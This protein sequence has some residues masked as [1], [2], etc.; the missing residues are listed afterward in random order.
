MSGQDTIIRSQGWEVCRTDNDKCHNDYNTVYWKCYW[1]SVMHEQQNHHSWIKTKL[2]KRK[3]QPPWFLCAQRTAFPIHTYAS[4]MNGVEA[5]PLGEGDGEETLTN[6]LLSNELKSYVCMRACWGLGH[7]FWL[8]IWWV[9]QS[10][11]RQNI[12]HVCEA[13]SVLF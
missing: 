8:P 1:V 12:E 7:S 3:L 10:S 2:A 5:R 4:I 9:L 13:V 6:L 11:R